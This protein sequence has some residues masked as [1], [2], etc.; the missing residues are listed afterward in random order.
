[1]KKIKGSLSA[2]R[3]SHLVVFFAV[4]A[5]ATLSLRTCQLLLVINP[6]TNQLL[7]N[8]VNGF[9]ETSHFTI[10]LLY[11][12]LAI[13]CI[14][15][16]VLSFLSKNVPAPRLPEGRNIPLG[17]ASL[18]AAAAFVWD[19][20]VVALKVIPTMHSGM[21]QVVFDG[22]RDSGIKGNG[23]VFVILELVFAV[24]SVLYFLVFGLSHFEGKATYKKVSILSIAPGCWTMFVLVSK[25][26]KAIS[27]ITVSE[28]LFEIGMLVFTM[29][30]FLTFAR[31]ASGVFS[32]NSMWC[33]YGC[34]F[35][36]AIFMGLVSIP[37]GI[38]LVLGN[39]NVEGSDFSFT[40][41]F[42][43]IFII[44]YMISTLGVGFKNSL[45]KMRSV[46]NIVLPDDSEV[47]VKNSDSS[48]SVSE[49]QEKE[50]EEISQK[51]R[52]F[53]IA[54]EF[55]NLGAISNFFDEEAADGEAEVEDENNI[56]GDAEEIRETDEIIEEV[57]ENE[58]VAEVEVTDDFKDIYSGFPV[59]DV[60]FYQEEGTVTEP[61]IIENTVAEA[62]EDYEEIV[63]EEINE[64]S[65]EI[66][67]QDY[68]GGSAQES[69]E[70][71]G[72][73]ADEKTEEI[74]SYGAGEDA[75][76]ES[77][78]N[79]TEESVEEIIEAEEELFDCELT[80]I[81][82]NKPV[83]EVAEPVE[84]TVSEEV[85]AVDDDEIIEEAETLEEPVDEIS[86]E[87]IAEAEI[88]EEAEAVEYISEDI[89]EEVA[90][91]EEKEAEE[92]PVILE[93]EETSALKSDEGFLEFSQM[94][95]DDF[96]EDEDLP[97]EE[98]AAE[99]K[100]EKPAVIEVIKEVE[101][102]NEKPE[103]IKKEKVKEEKTEKPKKEKVKK[104]KTPKATKLFGK[105]KKNTVDEEPLTIVSLAELRQKKDEE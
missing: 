88:I 31:I 90:F 87:I 26:M 78:E 28:L 13:S 69:T 74:T 51:K 85:S 14:L 11:G 33:T 30:F 100:V 15:F 48:A 12:I 102:K 3:M 66:A 39:K 47:V 60:S 83:I 40:H 63:D 56:S 18:V 95:I 42:L 101:V 44:V 62:V 20:I 80:D 35:P 61:E 86:E 96:D 50:Q 71:S 22:L 73:E 1:M 21:N 67:L 38:V 98:P 37:R 19:I 2:I 89:V 43:F 94:L 52:G 93:E 54:P 103:K 4:A 10:P 27:F 59:E 24:L 16:L 70:E 7:V 45:K 68:D 77:A 82:V 64:D 25:L 55:K 57:D 105:K 36:A 81:F 104:E 75:V 23:G 49:M 65:E 53:S 29:L 6:D 58:K 8:P 17:I 5:V 34:G 97:Q 92:A 99:Q 91:T 32:V 46:S 79:N 41:L 76:E 9:Y 84:E 72:G